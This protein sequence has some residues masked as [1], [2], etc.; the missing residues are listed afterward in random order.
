MDKLPNNASQQIGN[1]PGLPNQGHANAA[2]AQ[3]P[4]TVYVNANEFAAKA[5]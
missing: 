5:Q 1:A 4:Q 2:Q 3:I